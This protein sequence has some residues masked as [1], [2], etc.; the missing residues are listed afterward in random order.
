MIESLAA[1]AANAGHDILAPAERAIEV[2]SEKAAQQALMGLGGAPTATGISVSESNA[3]AYMPVLACSRVVSE[4]FACFVPKVHR[5]TPDGPES[6][7]THY[8]YPVVHD[9]ANEEMSAFSLW[10]SVAVSLC[11]FNRAY[12][13]IDWNGGG[14]VR[15]LWPVPPNKVTHKRTKANRLYFEIETVNGPEQVDPA[16]MLYIPGCLQISP[17]SQAES[18]IKWARESIGLGLAPQQYAS[19]FYRNNARPG[20]YLKFPN[21]L[22]PDTRKQIAMAWNDIHAGI[23]GAGRTGVIEGGGELVTPSFSMEQAQFSQTRQ[24]QLLEICRL[25]R[26]PPPMLQDYSRAT[27]SNVEHSDISLGKHTMTPYCRRVEAEANRKLFGVGSEFYLEF[28]MDALLRGDLESRTRSYAQAIN[29]SQMTPNEARR[30]EN[31]PAL[32]GGDRLYIQGANVPLEQAGQKRTQIP[33]K[34]TETK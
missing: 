7:D 34:G 28:N 17:G 26:V 10:E 12:V 32:P 24:D 6:A 31:R 29:T 9:Q 11:L 33:A 5:R 14:R 19:N 30:K 16:D 22:N 20:M 25:Y 3:L 2:P 23:Q 18:L 8:V 13:L 1:L 4:T 15:G 27:Y 21:A